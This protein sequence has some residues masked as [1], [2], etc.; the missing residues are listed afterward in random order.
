MESQPRSNGQPFA[1]ESA[2]VSEYNGQPIG[3][4]QSKA[5]E[6]TLPLYHTH[7]THHDDEAKTT[8]EHNRHFELY[9]SRQDNLQAPQSTATQ[10]YIEPHESRDGVHSATQS[11][12]EQGMRMDFQAR[13]PSESGPML[14]QQPSAHTSEASGVLVDMR[15]IERLVLQSIAAVEHCILVSHS[16]SPEIGCLMTLRTASG[17]AGL[18][19]DHTGLQLASK[20][21]SEAA[22]VMSARQCSYFRRGLAQAL[23]I[24]NQRID[25]SLLQ[26]RRFQVLRDRFTVDNGLLLP[27][28]ELDRPRILERYRHII[29]DMYEFEVPPPH[30]N[31]P[32]PPLPLTP[33]GG[34]G[35]ADAAPGPLRS[36]FST[37]SSPTQAPSVRPSIPLSPCLAPSHPPA[38]A[39]VHQPGR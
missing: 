4:E 31:A 24:V 13:N 30:P 33:T 10:K 27:D 16:T 7:K 14:R 28:G 26:I 12:Q 17:S 23:Q 22:T 38:P 3:S 35:G 25:G 20:C 32:P 9:N 15:P 6:Y 29:D 2:K 34:P 19:L 39:S 11:R 8:Y 21:G 1:S 37:E 36:S 5:P 18:A